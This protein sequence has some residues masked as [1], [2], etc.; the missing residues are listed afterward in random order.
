MAK[1][2][3]GFLLPVPRSNIEEYRKMA[4]DACAVWM[5]YGALDY[6]ECIADDIKPG[7]LTSF[8]Q[9]VQLKPNETVVFAWILYESKEERDRINELAMKDPR[10]TA[11]DPANMPFDGPRMMW[12]GF[13]VT[14]S[15]E[16]SQ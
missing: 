7:D 2:I 15:P 16:T 12:G 3:D 10:M 13:Q 4:Q 11:Y 8:P 1:Y 14:V 9:A 6:V 5:E